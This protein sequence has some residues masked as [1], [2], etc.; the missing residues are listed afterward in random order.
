MGTIQAESSAV[1]DASPAEIYAIFADYLNGHPHILPKQY[2][3]DLEVEEGGYGAGTR[4]RVRTRA[5]G[6]ERPYHMIVS[7]PEPGRVLAERDVASDLVTT[8]TVTPA[9]DGRQ[10]NV[11]I[12]TEWTPARGL[13]G[14]IERMI[15][16]PVMRR[17]Y[18]TELGQLA[19]YVERKRAAAQT[20]A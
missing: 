14:W 3:S 5:L 6:V 20:T 7:E 4:F 19:S 1:L 8:F 18:R 2:F 16:P 17:M 12:A 9:G 10:A 11:R 15:T 13:G